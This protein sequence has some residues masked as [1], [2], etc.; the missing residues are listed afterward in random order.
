MAN[1]ICII[2]H[3]DQCPYFDNEYYGY[4]E[5]CTK[6]K[7]VIPHNQKSNAFDLN[8]EIPEDCPLTLE[9]SRVISQ[10]GSIHDSSQG[11]CGLCGRLGCQGSCFK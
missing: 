5:I 9:H 2:S 8:H 7:R 3:C 1:R 10:S 4:S 6:L 11:H